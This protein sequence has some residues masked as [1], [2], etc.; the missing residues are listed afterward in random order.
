MHANSNN[1]CPT[2]SGCR[3][4]LHRTLLQVRQL[5][6]ELGAKDK[7]LELAR[8]TVER[9]SGEKAGLES[10]AAGRARE[11]TVLARASGA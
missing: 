10:A 5:R 2:L 1:F 9:L 3:C 8:R 4:P 6:E 11:R 7:A